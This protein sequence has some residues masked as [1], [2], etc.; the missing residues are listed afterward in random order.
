MGRFSNDINVLRESLSRAQMD[1]K[2]HIGLFP[3][4][5]LAR[6]LKVLEADENIKNIGGIDAARAFLDPEVCRGV[7]N[8]YVVTSTQVR[9]WFSDLGGI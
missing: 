5:Y 6:L 1:G 7:C 4:F 3:V 2:S 9:Q 8:G